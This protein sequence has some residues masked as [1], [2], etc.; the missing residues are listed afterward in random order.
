ME[1]NQKSKGSWM[2]LE[3]IK[4]LHANVSENYMERLREPQGTSRQ[5]WIDEEDDCD[6]QRQSAPSHGGSNRNSRRLEPMDTATTNAISEPS[7]LPREPIEFC[8]CESKRVPRFI[9]R[10]PGTAFRFP[11]PQQIAVNPIS[12][13][14]QPVEFIVQ[15]RMAIASGVED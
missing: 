14:D 4:I 12:Q 9:L 6:G 3:A 10:A 2:F 1:K 15:L 7:C 8:S 13:L 5:M 11:P